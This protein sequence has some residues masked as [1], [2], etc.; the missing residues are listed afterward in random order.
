MRR[1]DFC[2]AAT[3]SPR[4]RFQSGRVAVLKTS[5]DV[6]I[7]SHMGRG[8]EEGKGGAGRGKGLHFVPP[9]PGIDLSSLSDPVQEGHFALASVVRFGEGDRR[10]MEG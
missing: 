7:F 4:L 5:R 3:C 10:D 1:N 6:G 8:R 9:G 2:F